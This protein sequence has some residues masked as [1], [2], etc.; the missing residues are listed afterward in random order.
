[1]AKHVTLANRVINSE[2]HITSR[3]ER[4]VLQVRT[5]TGQFAGSRKDLTAEVSALLRK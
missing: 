5:T 3:G 2:T 4:H 1:M